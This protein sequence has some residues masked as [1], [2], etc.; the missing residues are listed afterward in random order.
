MPYSLENKLV[1]AVTSRAL[2][3]LDT[4]HSIFET[5]GLKE[6]KAFQRKNEDVPLEAGTG[7]PLIRALL[8]ING[9][10]GEDLVEVILVSRNDADS[11]LLVINSI[12][13][14][15]LYISRMAFTG[16]TPHAEYLEAFSC[17]LFLS[18]NPVDVRDAIQA[19][20]AA[21]L[22]YPP[23]DIFELDDEQVR[24]A[25]DGDNVLFGGASEEIYQRDG[26]DAFQEHEVALENTPLDPGPFKGFLQAL[27]HIQKKFPDGKSPIR[28]ALVTARGAAAGTR[29][30]KTLREW[31]ISLDESFFLDG[32]GKSA[33]LRAFKPHI[34]FDDQKVHLETA[35]PTTPSAQVPSVENSV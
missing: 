16:G 17:D 14:S 7:L 3:E 8:K 31:N 29:V 30:I 26:L 35:S 2:F 10:A 12:E 27:S 18:A 15:N 19:G 24:I 4:A 13:K 20:F 34:F 33:I 5:G 28:T 23:P 6:Y 32:M 9:K 11:G 1:V 25:F 21:A 22:V